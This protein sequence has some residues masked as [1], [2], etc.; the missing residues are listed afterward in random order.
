MKRE[1]LS[2]VDFYEREIKHR[3]TLSM[4][5]GE[6]DF[7]KKQGLYWRAACPLHGGDN[8]TSFSVNTQTLRWHC[9][10]HC[11]DG[12][13]IMYVNQGKQPHHEDF[14]RVVKMLA[15][16][17]NVETGPIERE[18]TKEEWEYRGKKERT[19]ALR[20]RFLELTHLALLG[21]EGQHAIDYLI[22]KR[23]FT[24]EQIDKAEL[25]FYS[26][27]EWIKQALQQTGYT[28]AEIET[29][30]VIK[31]TRWNGRVVGTWRD[32]RGELATFWARDLHEQ[33]QPAEKYLYLHGTK[34]AALVAFGLYQALQ[35]TNTKTNLVLVEGL[36][37]VLSLQARGFLSVA[38]IGGAGGEMK[39]ERFE[40]LAALGVRSVTLLLDNDKAGC[41]G[42][43]QAISHAQKGN[44]IPS[45]YVIDPSHLG[46]D[47]DPDEFVRRNGLR[48]FEKLLEHRT[49][50]NLYKSEIL[51]GTISPQAPLSQKREAIERVLANT[52][53]LRG[54]QAALDYEDILQ[55]TSE[56]TGY[57]V[58]GI[59]EVA[60]E[61]ISNQ[62]REEREKKLEKLIKETQTSL[63]NKENV[64]QITNSL[65][66]KLKPL[67]AQ[68]L[69]QPLPFSVERLE[70]ESKKL[71][72]GKKSG[73]TSLDEAGVRFG[74]G[75]LALFG[76]R[77]GHGKTSAL[78]GLLHNWLFMAEKEN[79]EELFLLYSAEEA[80]VRIYHRLLS[81]LTTHGEGTN[82]GWTI[83]EIGDF[84]QNPYSRGHQ[85]YWPNTELLEQAK[86][87]LHRWET[88]VMIIYR[89]DWTVDQ[90]EAHAKIMAERR[91]IGAIL[92]DY[93]QRVP[94]PEASFERRDIAVSTVARQ[95]KSLA[96]ELS[97]PLVT[98]AQ[99]NREAIKEARALPTD[100]SFEDES[101]KKA[102]RARR[103][104]LHHLREGGSEQEADLVLGIMNHRTDFEMD[105]EDEKKKPVHLP[106]VTDL[107]I[108][109][110][111]NRYGDVGR[112]VTLAY[113]GRFLLIQDKEE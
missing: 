19:L 96:V 72:A 66:A 105:A 22:T 61:R 50:A 58:E 29:S 94:P 99:I 17:V 31:D 109:I 70:Q 15:A 10:S 36:L 42:I 83:K 23:G 24:K 7:K 33:N 71:P 13:V 68:Q 86:S 28:E 100:K 81:L 106:N 40:K 21:P 101:I 38:G 85:Y 63:K 64:L 2:I 74:A 80:E 32:P 55:L 37:D 11:G 73:W 79:S 5:Y 1:Q 108:G 75:E 45:L 91:K 52:T 47:K 48:A 65:S 67:Q 82:Q 111:K 53:E 39:A 84:L 3:L 34:K 8:T 110:L 54:P 77:T 89:P 18:L 16:L 93:L 112:W 59:R 60:T 51:L 6:V 92:V 95:L 12:D 56:K 113:T 107:D 49:P 41:D 57:S 97:V 14:V 26:T 90:I 25:G 27:S 87:R 69:D 35:R 104:K 30:G 102:L 20:E 4:V 46:D 43:L 103:P 78:I 62:E 9:Y 76:A 44:Q 88:N 98:G